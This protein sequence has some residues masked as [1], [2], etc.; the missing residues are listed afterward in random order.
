M[1]TPVLTRSGATAA[2]AFDAGLPDRMRVL[3]ITTTQRTGDWLAKAFAADSASRVVLE[4]AVGSMA[5]LA[6]LRDEI[7]DAVLVSHQPG[8]LDALE[9]IEGYR[10]G[11]ADAPIVV[12]GT[13]SEQEMSV[14]CY[15]LGADAYVCIN[16]ATTRNL[17]WVVARAVQRHRLL[18][19]NARLQQAQ[20]RRLQQEHEEANQLLGQQRAMIE[21]LELLQQRSSAVPAEKLCPRRAKRGKAAGATCR[22][23]DLPDEL[24]AH[25]R[26]LLRTYV[27][28]GSGNLACELNQLGEL[29]TGAGV[30]PRETMQLHLYVLEELVQGLGARSTRHVMTRADLLVLEIMIHLGEGYRARYRERAEPSLQKHLPGFDGGNVS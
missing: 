5:G 20:Q 24:I 3:Y 18:R 9:L 4:E 25:Y 17:I 7:F 2:A 29:L 19:D 14:F 10:T 8:E 26:E 12:L 21:D 15:E 6:R 27:I 30:S 23:P 13:E 22:R 11:V 28:M 1:M 16:T